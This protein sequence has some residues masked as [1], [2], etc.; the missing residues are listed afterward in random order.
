MTLVVLK[1]IKA[2]MNM[3]EKNKIYYYQAFIEL[4]HEQPIELVRE[5]K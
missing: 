2:K 3:L 4:V 1:N 5:H